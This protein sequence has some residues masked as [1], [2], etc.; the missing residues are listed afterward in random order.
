MCLWEEGSLGAS[1][2]TIL[3]QSFSYINYILFNVINKQYSHVQNEGK[4]IGEID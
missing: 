2:V 1:C 4:H 3:V